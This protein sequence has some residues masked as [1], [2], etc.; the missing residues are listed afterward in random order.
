MRS[1]GVLSAVVAVLAVAGVLAGLLA[2]VPARAVTPQARV[3]LSRAPRSA[4]PGAF[5]AGTATS[6]DVAVNGYG[7]SAGYHLEVGLASSGFAWREV[8]VLH[9]ADLDDSSWTGY[10]C[11]SGD[12]KFAAVAVL[13]QSAV[14]LESARDHGAYA[15]SVNLATGAVRPIASG[16]GLMYFSPGCGTGDEAV[17]TLYPGTGQTSTQLVAANLATGHVTQVTTV[18]GQVSSAI[19]AT[20][21][22]IVG[23]LGPDLVS[24]SARG[25]T[26]VL[27]QVGGTPFDLRPAADGGISMLD[28]RAGSATSQALHER[29]GTISVLG[30][31]PLDAM[32]LF[33]GRRG[34][35]ILTGT[36]SADSGQL[37][38]AGVSI[39]SDHGLANGVQGASLD[40]TALIGAPP[41]KKQTVPVLLATATGKVVTDS[42]A[43]P[44][45]KPDTAVSSFVPSGAAGQAAPDQAGGLR[46]G[47]EAKGT[48]TVA[49]SGTQQ[50]A[51]TT[52]MIMTSAVTT[53][54]SQ[55][56]TCAVPRLD[57]TKQVMQP[58]PQQIDWA[59][60]MAEQGL[61]TTGNG[62]SRP[63]NFDNLGLVAYAPN[64]DFPLIPLDHPSG[65]SWNTV[66][67]SVFEAIMAQ[68]SN[69]SQASWHA[70]AGVSGDPLIADYYGAGGGIDSIDY[71]DADC[72]Y[73]ISQVT[74]GMHVGD[75]SLS[76]HGQIKVAVD[77]EENI[78]AGLQILESTWNQLYSDGI[79]ANNG[80]PRYL[81]NW[82]YAAW[83][84]NSGIEPTGSYDPSG[85]TAGPSCTGPDGTWGLGWANNPE[86]PAYP[87][88]RDPYLKDTYADAAHPGNWPYE[89]RIMGWMASPIIRY[90]GS[91]YSDAYSTPTYN[92]G[93]TWLQIPP[94]SSFCTM[95]GNDCNPNATNTT[96][97][98]NGHC[99]L[100]DDECWWHQSVTWDTT[101]ATTCATSSYA[102]TT[103][104]TQPSYADP[105]PPTCNVSTSD[106]PSGSII[107][108]DETSPPLN[109]QGC[110]GE[111]WTSK[112]TFTYTY[113]T[114]SAGDPIGAIDTHQLGTGL[115]GHILFTHTE[116]G[117]IPAEIN[118]GTWT[119]NLPSLQYYNVI[120]HFPGLGAEATN[121][122]YTINP[123]GGVAPWKISVNQAWNSEHWASIGTFAMENGGNVVLTNQSGNVDTTGSGYA[124]YDVAFDAI[125]FVPMGGTPGQPIGGPP[126][127]Q[128]EPNGSNPAWVQC[129]CGTRSAGDPVNTATGYF[130]QSWTDLSTPGRGMPLDFS[131]T[132]T[133][134]TADP[135]GP[136]GSLATD[137]PFGWGWT[138]AYN[139]HATTDSSTGDVTVSQEDGS[140]VTFVDSGG[141]YTPSAPRY[142]ATLTA[143]GSDYVYTRQGKEV[144]T[145]DQ[146]TGHLVE[147]QDLAGEKA[148]TPYGTTLA[149]NTAGQLHTITD[150]AGRVYTL[151]WTG[152][153]I[154][155]LEDSAG[156]IVT[157]AYDSSDDL[158]DVYGVG[159][160]RSPTLQDNDHT[161]FT[162]TAAH[163]MSSIRTPDNYGGAASAVTSMTYDSAERVTAQTGPLGNNTTTFTYGPAGGLSTGQ[164]LVTDPSGHETL[165]TYSNGLL[166]SETRGYGT[167]N[168]GTWSYTYDPVSL[169]VSA[170]TDPDGHVTTYTYDANGNL[171]SKSNGLGV[172]TNYLYDSAGDLLE[173][174]D[175]DGV[176]TVNQYDQAGHIP[177]GATGVDD[178]TSTTVTQANNVV[179][180]STGILGTAPAR[181]TNYYYDNAADP[182]DRTRVVDPDSNTT[183][184][185]YDAYG[186]VASATDALG[187]KILYGYN[188]ATGWGTSMVTPAGVAAGTT[189]SCSPPA[190][191]CVTYGYDAYGHITVTT[192]ALGNTTKATY[193]ADGNETSTTD[194]NGNTVTTT[195]DAD[196]RPVKV[197]QAD[198]AQVT[199]YNPDGTVAATFDGLND[200]TTYGYDGQGRQDSQTDPDSRTT[201]SVIDPAGLATS[202]T[203]ASGQTTTMTHDAA[204]ELTGASYSDGATPSVSY[205][206]DLDGRKT[207][208]TDGTGTTTWAYDV[209][210]DVTS[211]TTGAGETVG[212]GYD[213]AGNQTSITYPDEATPVSQTYNGDN[214]LASVTD[215]T[216]NKT[217]FG[218]SPDGTLQTTSYPN[219]DTVTDGYDGTDTLTSTTVSDSGTTVA[220]Y[221][222]GRDPA[223]QVSSTTNASGT[224]T[225]GYTQDEQLSSETG[226]AASSFGY[227]AANNPTT[228][229]TAT[230]AFDAAGQLKTSG[231]T[232]YTYSTEGERTA[233]T[234]A[235]GTATA[236]SY[237]QAGQLTGATNGNGTS[238]YSYDGDGLTA[239]QTE[240]GTT[241]T[242]CWND[243][244]TPGLLTDG[245]STYLYGPGGLPIE[246]A[247]A[248]GTFWFV[249][250]QVGSTLVLLASGGTIAGGYSYTPYG[251]ATHTGTATTPLQY[252]GQYTDPQTG[253]VYLRARYYDPTTALF[254]TVDPMVE[255]THAAYIYVAD[256][257]LNGV[258]LTGL[259]LSGFGWF[260]NNAGYIA[261]GLTVAAIVVTAVAC[262]V[263]DVVA[264][265][266]GLAST[267]VS[268]AG[269]V[270]D[271]SNNK[272]ATATCGIDIAGDALSFADFGLGGKSLIKFAGEGEHVVTATAEA[273]ENAAHSAFVAD[274]AS[275]AGS[276]AGSAWTDWSNFWSSSDAASST[277]LSSGSSAPGTSGGCA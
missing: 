4:S 112:G 33:G 76:A 50:S 42:Q 266:I 152:S 185:T 176:A 96:T 32:Q 25:S 168:A 87:P 19:P 259:C 205:R 131:R 82:F 59:A 127:V 179:E 247:S 182:G 142:D 204:G 106:V 89:E 93:Q 92:G 192:N 155:Q 115:G 147:E 159:T 103:G 139:L 5:G 110:S 248:A 129:T 91:G 79:L 126:T 136:N 268:V 78:A 163:L 228:V 276:I 246:Q 160:T 21:G 263:C 11:V 109:L 241:A 195:Y 132:Y 208:M 66:P 12:G 202:T 6:A 99:Q 17:F 181:T 113:G 271:C 190:T 164:T 170:E 169:G 29:G 258:D 275:L 98:G 249:H 234:P 122:I 218:Y 46:P 203:N 156:R 257:P 180:S 70:P 85:C 212:Y 57:P 58:S 232:S 236:Y 45:A 183:T 69:W 123:G 151:T 186:D 15:Y 273:A 41:S 64:S 230:Q 137:G 227:D 9:P 225:Y 265:G 255:S 83:A 162:Y 72:G 244:S 80:D 221:S 157:Y 197:T 161:Q 141:T 240:S 111:N 272:L 233:A 22:G 61:L 52:A 138:F 44:S 153:H 130:G 264:L 199:D 191:G 220:A 224:E 86:N 150:P 146:A 274:M 193:D 133:E 235:S 97:P 53:T 172:T 125:A 120:V 213:S 128:A 81:E 216:G 178:L 13:P 135:S 262:T 149:Y 145:F 124:D 60:Q 10:Q 219:G 243:A 100:S 40:G 104:S 67:R 118:T 49:A 35:A 211:K 148:S 62:Y 38:A 116:T 26:S 254:L 229:G 56:P 188:T 39:V 198:G 51:E 210:G 177:S 43:K 105:D 30:T 256:N 194:A 154:T 251:L 223:E 88:N 209:F 121:V 1:G 117:S 144:F 252:T 36:T 27:A 95:A 231:G 187:N 222:F 143:S 239:T 184:T 171:T 237:N 8:A 217:K 238:S 134:A 214:Q 165:D 119:P 253:L 23:A 267:A 242:F 277:P 75:T 226:A 108:D 201:S 101:C 24:V 207:S 189:T 245:T 270:N 65:D 48:S 20:A 102:Y 3:S 31:G 90:N 261:T 55:S 269:T 94:F 84:Y 107:V 2:P 260:C 71:A 28:A 167:A 34:R 7:D 77:Y 54:S 174:I 196:D 37:T 206:Y 200:K 63:A 114:D 74:D 140:Q 18:S 175:G 68:E 166:T 14:N 250:D 47:P 215:W 16:V 173:T 73:G 158:T